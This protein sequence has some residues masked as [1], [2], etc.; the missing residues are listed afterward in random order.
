M[1]L[2]VLSDLHELT[3][4]AKEVP[5]VTISLQIIMFFGAPCIGI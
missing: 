1:Y 5:D 2:K 4:P 3:E